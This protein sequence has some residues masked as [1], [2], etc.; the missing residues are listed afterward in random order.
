MSV[1]VCLVV[2]GAYPYITGGVAN[3]THQLV[4]G[5]PEVRFALCV[6]MPDASFAREE[7]YVVPKNVVV[8][9]NVYLFDEMKAAPVKNLPAEVL[10]PLHRFHGEPAASR[11][12]FFGRID[13]LLQTARQTAFSLLSA[14]SSWDF[15]VRMYG[16]RGRQVSFLDYYWS[17]RST[18]GPVFRLLDV[19]LPKA[20]VYH[21][22]ST[23][24]AGCLAA[25]AKNRLGAGMLLT[26]HGIYTRER[27]IEIAQADWIY[28]EPQEGSA[29]VQDDAFFKTWWRHQYDFLGRLAYDAADRIVALNDVNRQYQVDAGANPRKLVNVPNGID[30]A[31][32]ESARKPRAW[33]DRPFRVGLVGRVVPIKDVKTFLRAVQLASLERPIEAFVLGPTDEDPDYYYECQE[34]A[35]T[36][37]I[38]RFVTFTG[39]VNVEQWLGDLDLNVLTSISESQPF[40]ILEGWAAGLPSVSTDVGACREMIEGREGEDALLGPAGFVC[41]VATP[42]AVAEA[43]VTLA[44]DP[45]RH[46][47]MAEAGYARLSRFYRLDQVFSAYRALYGELAR[48]RWSA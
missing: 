21:P 40:A 20:K 6:I 1:D 7:R 46:R 37:G 35:R 9:Q 34:L 14:R 3:W 25:I 11:C 32:F 8:R 23:G 24:Y 43:I 13:Y 39:K 28:R 12:P 2:E 5:L 36:L 19:P 38:Q 44:E 31:R 15:L 41:P 4:T 48:T 47:A 33:R 27:A 16:E 42:Q 30:L 45:D 18:H 17:W 10:E 22:L 26:E 29:Y